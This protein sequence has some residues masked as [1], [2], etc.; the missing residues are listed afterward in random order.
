VEARSLRRWRAFT[1]AN[2]SVL[3]ASQLFVLW[4]NRLSSCVMVPARPLF[5]RQAGLGAIE[6]PDLTFLIDARHK[7]DPAGSDRGRQ[8][9]GFFFK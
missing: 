6:R 7:R 3:L 2:P 4:V 8:C 1:H 9:L 5:Q